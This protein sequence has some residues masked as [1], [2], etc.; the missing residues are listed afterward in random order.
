M[1]KEDNGARM[2]NGF[3]QSTLYLQHF[4][5]ISS[6]FVNGWRAHQRFSLNFVTQAKFSRQTRE[7]SPDSFVKQVK[8]R[9]N[10][11]Q[12]PLQFFA[13]IDSDKPA[14]QPP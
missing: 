10:W 5:L 14:L 9:S 11:T 13:R 3:L 12:I 6:H 4:A 2:D 1:Q 8:I 7:N